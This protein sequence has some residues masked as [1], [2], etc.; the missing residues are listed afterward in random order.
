MSPQSLNRRQWICTLASA[1]AATVGWG[2]RE[3]GLGVCRAGESGSEAAVLLAADPSRDLFRVRVELDIEGNVDVPTNAL[4][5]KDKAAQVP[6]RSRSVL[7]WEERILGYANDRTGHWAERFYFE[8]QSSGKMGKKEQSVR[9]RSQSQAIRVQRDAGQWV[10]Y[11]PDSYLE[12]QEIDLLKVPASSLAVD[13][14]LPTVA[15]KAGDQYR[16][17]KDVLAKLLSLA[18]VQEST[19]VG[20]VVSIEEATAR[21]HLKGKVDGSVSGVPTTIDLVAK[22]VFDREQSVC[23]WLALAI[24]EVRE[25]G[26]S[27]PGFDIAGTIRMIRKPLDSPTRLST[28]ASTDL[29]TEVPSDRLLTELSSGAVGFSVLMD[30]RWKIMA[31]AAGASMMRMVE[32]DRGI[33]Q[34]NFTPLGKMAAGTQLTLEA[35]VAESQTSM[36][37]RF[38]EVLRSQEDVNAAGLR[39]MRVVIQGAVQGV[40]VQWAMVQFSDDQGRRLLATVTVANEHIELFAGADE[41]MSG[42][43]RFLPLNDATHEVAA[44]A[45]ERSE[46]K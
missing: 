9:L 29:P 5:S 18:G 35:F 36:G 41:Q 28:E 40:P 1:T 11:S 15:V 33:A 21:I 7:D 10:V 27:E 17:D 12:G 44:S 31:D 22:M 14:L 16:P 24:H 26:K 34:A 2:H 8:A 19:V 30:R 4:V 6:V 23:T 43:L 32:D 38:V 13:A 25:I 45:I 3:L 39:V 42:S 46:R 37:E 20:E